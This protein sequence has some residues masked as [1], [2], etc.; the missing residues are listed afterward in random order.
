M[1]KKMFKKKTKKLRKRML[2]M[3]LA[4]ASHYQKRHFDKYLKKYLNKI[5]KLSRHS[6][7][8]TLMEFVLLNDEVLF[9]TLRGVFCSKEVA[10]QQ[11]Y[12]YASGNTDRRMDV[13]N[14]LVDSLCST[15][16]SKKGN[17]HLI[18]DVRDEKLIRELLQKTVTFASGLREQLNTAT[19]IAKTKLQEYW[20]NRTPP[21]LAVIGSI[22]LIKVSVESIAAHGTT[23][24]HDAAMVTLSFAL[25]FIAF[26]GAFLMLF[27]RLPHAVDGA[28]KQ[29]AS[30]Y[31]T[32]WK[33]P[34]GLWVSSSTSGCKEYQWKVDSCFSELKERVDKTVIT[35]MGEPEKKVCLPFG[36]PK[37][38]EAIDS[39][40]SNPDKQEPPCEV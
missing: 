34:L 29:K 31:Y 19:S 38:I 3:A 4:Y 35:I 20:T 28:S 12:I 9:D 8:D 26:L 22:F 37:T 21:M 10:R 2:K 32:S 23:N 16:L 5:V 33:G 25:I 39:E 24:D 30:D 7:N 6:G 14:K 40:L 15:L 1:F 11:Y 18:A 27:L 17:S 13:E 36:K